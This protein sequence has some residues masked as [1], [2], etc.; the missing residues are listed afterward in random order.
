MIKPV[1]EFTS[2]APMLAVWVAGSA[3]IVHVPWAV[4]GLGTLASRFT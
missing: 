1:G 4:P 2:D 3:P